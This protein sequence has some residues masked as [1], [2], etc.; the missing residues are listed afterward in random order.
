MVRPSGSVRGGSV[1]LSPFE[2]C[3]VI[4]VANTDH[5]SRWGT[6]RVH[7]ALLEEM[8]DFHLLLTDTVRLVPVQLGLHYRTIREANCCNPFELSPATGSIAPVQACQISDRV[9]DC[10]HFDLLDFAD[11]FKKHECAYTRRA[12]KNQEFNSLKHRLGRI[13]SQPKQRAHQ[14]DGAGNHDGQVPVPE[15][16]DHE[17]CYDG[18]HEAAQIS[19]AVHGARNGAGE[20][21]ANVLAHRPAGAHR[22]IA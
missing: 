8:F 12:C 10:D 13:D 7:S 22:Q 19:P 15:A 3:F 21:V 9:L 2:R 17:A 5:E 6:A 20:L 1:N 14:E 18:R 11:D 4:F 16:L